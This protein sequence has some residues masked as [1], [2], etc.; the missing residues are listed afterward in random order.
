ML[1]IECKQ[2]FHLPAQISTQLFRKK[3]RDKCTLCVWCFENTR[4]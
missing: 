4:H 1:S 2:F 3:T